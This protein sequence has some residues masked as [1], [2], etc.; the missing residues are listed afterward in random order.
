[1][2]VGLSWFPSLLNRCYS[3]WVS[4]TYPFA[5]IGHNLSLHYS[6]DLNRHMSHRIV[7]GDSVQM[8]RGAWVYVSSAAAQR[9]EPALIIGDNCFIARYSQVAACNRIEL[10]RDVILSANSLI[11]DHLH[12]FEDV[13]R[14]VRLQGITEGGRIRIGQ[15][16]WIGH[17]AAIVCDHGVLELGR[18]CVVGVN[19]VV[20]KSFP[21]YS[22][23]VGNPARVVRQFDPEKQTWALGASR[24]T[25]PGLNEVRDLL[26]R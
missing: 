6:V 7:I 14:P 10:E 16:C 24:V 3:R 4:S 18:N 19:A 9:D 20:T 21:A 8:D 13:S 5:C 11:V 23:I 22:V 12:A 17:G 15:G 1:M 26:A 2:R 25:M